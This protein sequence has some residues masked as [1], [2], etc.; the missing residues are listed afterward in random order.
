MLCLVWLAPSALARGRDWE[1]RKTWVFEDTNS[2]G[3]ISLAEL[4]GDVKEDMSFT[5]NERAVFT[6]TSD[7]SP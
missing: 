1:P 3:E 2:D 7:F 5:E 6:V 4:A